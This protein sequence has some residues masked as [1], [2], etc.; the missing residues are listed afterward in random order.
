[1]KEDP[2]GVGTKAVALITVPSVLLWW[3]NKDD[4]R[5]KNLP[6]WQKDLFWI[7]ATDRWVP[8]AQGEA[9]GLPTYLLREKN[10][11]TEINKGTIFR[12]PKPQELGLLFGSLVERVL[13]K[14]FTDN[15][16]ATKDF[17]KTME[18]ILAPNMIP[19]AITPFIEQ[20]FNK[21]LFTDN[22]II[23]GH[24]ED[25]APEY[26]YTEYTTESAKQLAKMLKF[27]PHNPGSPSF[28]SPMVLENY[29]Q[30]WSGNIGMHILRVADQALYKTGVVPEPVQPASTLADIPVI[31]AFVVRYPS[32]SATSIQDF[33]DNYAVQKEHFDTITY[34]GKSQDFQDLQKELEKIGN[35]DDVFMKLDG[36]KKALTTQGQVIHLIYKNPVYTADEKRQLIDGVYYGMIQEAQA[37][38]DI[39]NALEKVNKELKNKKT[40]E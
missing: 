21:S 3:A 14:F 27:L 31:K 22:K 8:A 28:S 7:V 13:E 4:E 15:P 20:K 6:R 26:Q 17:D 24:L 5:V 18:N 36:M 32:A 9:E 34:L 19:D 29:V 12:V 16:D 35:G 39:L 25:V 23:P 40:N 11:V 10:G 33:Y 1:M 30:A 38:N 2:I 37:G